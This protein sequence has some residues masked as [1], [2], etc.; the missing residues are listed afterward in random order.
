MF[1]NGML[2]PEEFETQKEK[3][4][5]AEHF[6]K[7]LN[8]TISPLKM[9][10]TKVNWLTYYRVNER[11]AQ[12][13]TYKGRIFLAGDAAHVHSPAGG[14]GMN[15]GLQ[16]AYNLAWKIA[17]VINGTAP[18]SLLNS[19]NEERPLIG[20]EIIKLS[21]K[22]LEDTLGQDL[23]QRVLKRAAIALAPILMP[24]MANRAPTMSMVSP[25]TVF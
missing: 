1:D 24:V 5:T 6:Q 11:R 9:T 12:E 4:L 23:V 8:E 21:A 10:I 18:P 17:M 20:D 7:L 15:T 2:T 19:Y 22:T 3:P 14:Q 16:D 13:Y 25:I